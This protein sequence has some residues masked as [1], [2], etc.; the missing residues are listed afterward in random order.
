MGIEEL[1]LQV[2]NLRQQVENLHQYVKTIE[3]DYKFHTSW[4][5]S[6]LAFIVTA[7]GASLYFIAKSIVNNRITKEMDNRLISLLKNNPPIF[8]A[9][10]LSKPDENKKIYLSS[11]IQGIDQLELANIILLNVSPE[12][13]TFNDFQRKFNPKINKNELGIVEIEI[14]EYH[15]NNGSVQWKIV[16][17][18]KHY[19]FK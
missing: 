8:S 1:I 19:D 9:S 15:E 5:L 14:P 12:Q 11:A 6:V 7:A 18:R 4:L 16:W 10:G 17:L 2:E 3:G 13:M